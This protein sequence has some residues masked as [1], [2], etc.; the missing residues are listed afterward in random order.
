MPEPRPQPSSEGASKTVATAGWGL[1]LIWTGA[2]LFL[3]WSWGV[4]LVGAGV[5]VL[6]AQVAR[7]YLR[8]KAEGL[9]IVAGAAMLVCGLGDL[10]RMAVDLYPVLFIVAGIALLVSAWARRRGSGRPPDEE[11]HARPGG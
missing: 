5:I 11:A 4:G 9:S 8:L 2:A 3:H 10:S 6:G 1:L 7:W